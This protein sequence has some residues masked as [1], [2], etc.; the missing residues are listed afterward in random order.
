[1]SSSTI[2]EPQSRWW[3]A[4]KGPRDPYP[5]E[6][7]SPRLI[8]CWIHDAEVGLGGPFAAASVARWCRKR[9]VL[10]RPVLEALAAERAGTDCYSTD[11]LVI[12]EDEILWEDWRLAGDTACCPVPQWVIGARTGRQLYRFTNC[13]EDS[14]RCEK[15]ARRRAERVLGQARRDWPGLDV[16]Y[17]AEVEDDGGVINRVRSTRRVGRKAATTWFVKRRS[18]RGW[19]ER[20]LVAFWSTEDLA[21]P[22]TTKP[23]H[24][25]E[26]LLPE[27]ALERLAHALRLPGVIGCSPHWA[28]VDGSNVSGEPV[29]ELA[30]DPEVE[31]QDQ[32]HLARE[33]MVRL[34]SVMPENRDQ[35]ME[36]AR[37]YAEAKWGFQPSADFFPLDRAPIAEWVKTIEVAAKA[38]GVRRELQK[39][40]GAESRQCHDF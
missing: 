19:R 5:T 1:M 7:A 15:H 21:G 6:G 39:R 35:A 32:E 3:R 37:R 16:V 33:Q 40:K 11:D 4:A 38:V 9:G 25:W 36:L 30:V 26:P 27:E 28:A 23:P 2:P 14:W 8:A 34:P 17:W 18:W 24:R 10:H 13:Y 20:V 12:T 22:R 29:E 31:P